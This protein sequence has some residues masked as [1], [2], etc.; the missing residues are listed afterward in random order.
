M[1]LT[2]ESRQGEVKQRISRGLVALL[3]SRFG[4]GPTSA[5]AY[6]SDDVIT[7]VLR[8]NLTP[9]E[10]TLI[11]NERAAVVGDLREGFLSAICDE[12]VALVE[13][14][15]GRSVAAF[16]S[17]HNVVSDIAVEVFVL[18][19]LAEDEDSEP[20]TDRAKQDGSAS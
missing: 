9:V 5:R 18:E 1:S 12:A 6:V 13:R 10:H 14:E 19:P 4:R 2:E 11:E 8:D 7:V 3:K 17:D 15:T 16:L 20:C